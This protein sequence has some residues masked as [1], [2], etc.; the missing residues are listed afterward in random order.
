MNELQIA[1]YRG[2]IASAKNV[3][4]D[5]EKELRN[6]RIRRPENRR[7]AIANAKIQMTQALSALAAGG[8]SHDG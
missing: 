7:A 1:F 5:A 2:V 4:S 6:P 8:H 3:I